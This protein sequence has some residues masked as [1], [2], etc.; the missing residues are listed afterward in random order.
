MNKYSTP[1]FVFV[2]ITAVVA[3]IWLGNNTGS[4]QGLKPPVI[5]GAIYPRAKVLNDF[6]ILINIISTFY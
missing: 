3:G 5:Q 6:E 1:V 4:E 2:A